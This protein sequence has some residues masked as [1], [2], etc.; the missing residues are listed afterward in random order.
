VRDAGRVAKQIVSDHEGETGWLVAPIFGPGREEPEDVAKAFAERQAAWKTA[1]YVRVLVD[2]AEQRFDATLPALGADARVD[3][4]L[5][6]LTFGASTRARI[7]EAVEH[8]DA[9]SSGRVSVVI[10]SGGKRSEY[11]TR[12][13]CPACGFQIEG[14]LEPRHFSFNTHVGACPS[15]DGLGEKVEC[16]EEKLFTHPELAV[17]DGAIGGKLSRYLV[18]GKGYYEMLVRTVARVHKVDLRTP[19]RDLPDEHR[20]LLARGTGARA[21]YTVKLERSTTNA[22]IE[23]Q[24]TAAWPGLC[25]H[26]D[27]WRAK[28]EDAEW[29]AVLETAMEKRTCSTCRG[30]RLKPESS[31]VTVGKVRLPE[32]LVRSVDDALTWADE[33]AAKKTLIEA[34]GPVVHEVRSRLALLARVGLGYLTL[35][36]TTST[37]SGGE[38]RR[39]RLAS[40]LGSQLVGVCYVLDE[41]T[42]GLHPRDVEQLAG[43]LLELRDRGNTLLVVEHD[44]ALMRRAD[45]IVD[46]GPGAGRLGGEIL[47][48]A[49]PAEVAAHPTS[50]TAAA[51]RGEIV[52]TRAPREAQH[53]REQGRIK[54]TGAKLHNLKNAEF[55]FAFG[56]LTGVCGPSGSG[57]STLVLDTLV[58]AL[59]DEPAQGRWKK[60]SGV[61][62]GGARVVVVD[63]APIGR[64]PASI[65]A[66][67]CGVMEPLRELFAR[68]PDAKAKGYD[69][70]R[71][72]FN[73]PKG[74]CAACEGKGATQVE[75][76]FL[77]DLWLTCEECDGKRY[78]PEV[79]EV[80]F[81]G[82]SIADVL[83]LS[84]DE[85]LEFCAHQPQIVQVLETLRDVGLGYLQLGQSSTTLSG[86]EAQRVKLASEL[87]R[88]SASVRSVV[89]L[90]EPSTGLSASDVVHL[91]RVLDRLAAHGNAVIVIEHHT[92]LLEI[93]DQ[94]VEIGPTGGEA[95]GYV[96]AQGTPRE[97][98]AN[99]R[100]VT[101]P[102]LFRPEL[103]FTAPRRAPAAKQKKLA[104]EV[105]S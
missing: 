33:L 10:K 14:E 105:G 12:G 30:E 81:R 23:E 32:L 56:E 95:G 43:A 58:P 2:G 4:V 85:A 61:A 40:S 63:A 1:G 64:T 83:A 66:T 92:G 67:Y 87:F 98:A 99:P 47:A 84:V 16:T 69:A 72:S 13:T 100:S 90:D 51:L 31:A 65:P 39:V 45:W 46:V 62:G 6:R 29:A 21:S 27:A 73:S 20:A 5:D 103:P 71:F 42:V 78:A 93:C 24:F 34:V 76:Q 91:A 54:L 52:L 22:E 41:P 88:A 36:R 7:A 9:L 96:V 80:R 17:A 28:T 79:L 57:K 101:G 11:G 104:R 37:L 48:S 97:L 70:G 50:R 38:A 55:E 44:T 86:G 53:A 82:K 3:L 19:W 35:D 60:L 94:L 77:A 26:V 18:K 74:R 25:G 68:T 49:P 102:F 75:M 8:A 15:C 59:W 89:V